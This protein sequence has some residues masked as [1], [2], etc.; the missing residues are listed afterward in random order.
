MRIGII[1]KSV[2]HQNTRRVAEAMSRQL[3]AHLLTLAD[4]AEADATQ[5]DLVGWG[6][7]IYFGRHHP[8]LLQLAATWPSLPRRSFVFST[9]G[10]SSLSSLWHQ[11]LVRTLQRRGSQ[12]IDQFSCPGWD[13]VG[14]LWMLGGLHRKRPDDADL[15]RAAKFAAGLSEKFAR[16]APVS[17]AT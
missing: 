17:R 16:Q 7:G 12:V 5:Y 13:T 8:E 11:P 4:A 10:I 2:H 14:P 1:Y 15:A 9:A 3:G 6:S